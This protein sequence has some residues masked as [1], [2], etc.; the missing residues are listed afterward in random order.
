MVVGHNGCQAQPAPDEEVTHYRLEARLAALE[1]AAPQE[2]TAFGGQFDDAWVEGVLG[3][4]VQ[5]D[6]TL[7]NGSHAIQHG[8]RQ[9]QVLINAVLKVLYGGDLRKHHHLCVGSPKNDHLAGTVFR[10]PDIRAQSIDDLHVGPLHDV[11]AARA[12]VRGDKLGVQGSL[13]RG[14]GPQVGLQ[15]LEQGRL[16][17]L[18]AQRCVIQVDA[19]DVPPADFEV[20]GVR[21]WQQLLDRLV[22]IGEGAVF[23]VE[24]K[25]N[26]RG[27]TLRE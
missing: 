22:H 18:R 12:L 4:A 26:M 21:H 8:C 7:L 5:V 2:G 15:L 11:V 25:A 23:R 24:G 17:D 9:R 1:V 10:L 6:D 27:G 14:D 19:R 3:G 16:Q 13:H 20:D